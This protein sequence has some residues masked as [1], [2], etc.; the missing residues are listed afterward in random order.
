MSASR[1]VRKMGSVPVFGLRRTTSAAPSS[2][3]V[4]TA[5]TMCRLRKLSRTSFTISPPVM[6]TMEKRT[7]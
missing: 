3:R 2:N 7:R 5:S 4:C 1:R 6:E